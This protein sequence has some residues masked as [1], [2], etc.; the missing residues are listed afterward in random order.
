MYC[1]YAH[2]VN[3]DPKVDRGESR[4]QEHRTDKVNDH[5]PE[6]SLEPSEPSS[7]FLVYSANQSANPLLLRARCNR[8]LVDWLV[9]HRCWVPGRGVPAFST[10]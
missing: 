6:P 5:D 1:D 3:E 7:E 4:A 9:E 8:G 10:H 2:F